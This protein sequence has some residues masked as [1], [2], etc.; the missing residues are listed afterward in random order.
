MPQGWLVLVTLVI[1][2][3]VLTPT[4]VKHQHA[5]GKVTLKASKSN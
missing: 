1:N 3:K 5:V 4:S 2:M